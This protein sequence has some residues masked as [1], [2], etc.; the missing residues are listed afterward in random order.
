[1]VTLIQDF[2]VVGETDGQL[3]QMIQQGPVNAA[4]TLRNSGINTINYHYQE[5]TGSGWT[6]MGL[7]GSDLYNTLMSGQVRTI[8]VT[9][10]YAQV[11]L[12][13]NASGG[14][15]LNFSVLREV[16]RPDG[17]QLPILNF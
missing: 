10:S 1:M 5:L 12:M 3:F 8:L 16:T 13:G 7:V 14:A 6:E 4:V 2:Q 11:R 15:T 17:G 9:S